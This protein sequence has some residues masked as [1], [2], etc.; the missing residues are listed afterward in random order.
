M[1]IIDLTKANFD[2]V[3]NHTSLMVVDFSAEW[4][5]PCESFFSTFEEVSKLYPSVVFG[6]VDIDKE[7]ELAED[8]NVQSIPLIMILRDNIILYCESGTLSLG[9]LKK[10]IEEAMAL[11]M[12]EVWTHLE[13]KPHGE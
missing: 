10:L 11:D 8:F 2:E 3:V 9:N 7:H 4:C 12:N 5:G 13:N 1:S 6:R